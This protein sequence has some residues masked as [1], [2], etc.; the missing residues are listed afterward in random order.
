MNYQLYKQTDQWLELANYDDVRGIFAQTAGL[1]P[2]TLRAIEEESHF[3][4]LLALNSYITALE[5]YNLSDDTQDQILELEQKFWTQSMLNCC[6]QLNNW[7]ILSK[8]IFIENTTFDTLWSNAHQLNYLM[9]Y[10]S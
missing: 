5:Q 4:F 8:H 9:S 1:K 6:N 10:T 2:I 3:D 7:S